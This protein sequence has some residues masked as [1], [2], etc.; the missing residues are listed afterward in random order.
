VCECVSVCECVC[1]SV[2]ASVSA[3]MLL[4]DNSLSQNGNQVNVQMIDHDMMRMILRTSLH[5]DAP[6]TQNHRSGLSA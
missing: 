6:Q 3:S 5:D 1:A 2:S 4:Q